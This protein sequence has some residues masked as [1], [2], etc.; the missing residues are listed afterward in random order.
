[1]IC[2]IYHTHT[3]V[4]QINEVHMNM[5]YLNIAFVLLIP[6]LTLLG[7]P[8]N[9]LCFYFQEMDFLGIIHLF[10]NNYWVFRS[11][12]LKICNLNSATNMILC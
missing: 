11:E 3:K 9:R 7:Y 1:M 5:I 10:Y 2:N 4:V 12:S 6:H 8:L